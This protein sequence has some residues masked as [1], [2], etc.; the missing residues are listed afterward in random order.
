MRTAIKPFRLQ[1]T[2]GIEDLWAG[3]VSYHDLM[4]TRLRP[5]GK[6]IYFSKH[7]AFSWE[8]EFRLLIS[9]EMA[10]EFVP[11]VPEGGIEVPV[12]LD[13]LIDHIM[14]GPEL[15]VE[16]RDRIIASSREAG[17]GDRVRK[18]SLLGQPR[19]I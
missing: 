13:A 16:D 6:T 1:P 4:T 18:S 2:Y 17:L 7:R 11:D 14:L 12:D 19:L 15:S 10:S 3:A 9:L 5:L 8:K